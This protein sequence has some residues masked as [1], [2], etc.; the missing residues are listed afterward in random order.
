[1]WCGVALLAVVAGGCVSPPP[2]APTLALAYSDIDGTPGFD[3]A[4]G[5]VLISRLVDSNGDGTASAGD[6]ATTDRYPLD[7]AATAFDRFDVN[8]HVVQSAEV[9]PW[10]TVEVVIGTDE[11]DQPIL[12]QWASNESV[13]G[14]SERKMGGSIPDYAWFVDSLECP[15]GE[16]EDL[17]LVLAGAPSAPRTE[18]GETVPGEGDRGFVDVEL[19]VF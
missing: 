5:D 7:V 8:R 19:R 10:G 13:E 17:L 2:S 9:D 4:N 14:Y 3:P 16:C 11:F 6:E 12:L 15:T 1:M 18:V